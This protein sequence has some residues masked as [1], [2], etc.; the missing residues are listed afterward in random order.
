MQSA[1]LLS[2]GHGVRK[3]TVATALILKISAI[4]KM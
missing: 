4:L 2:F 1:C 3:L